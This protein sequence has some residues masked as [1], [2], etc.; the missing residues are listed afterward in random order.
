MKPEEIRSS[1]E[2]IQ[3]NLCKRMSTLESLTKGLMQIT[4]EIAAQLAEQRDLNRRLEVV[5]ARLGLS[6]DSAPG[7][8]ISSGDQKQSV[9]A[10]LG[11]SGIEPGIR[12][13]E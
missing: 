2:E 10:Q 8:G 9:Q 1:A 6:S 11:G 5:E 4:A 7:A 13:E 3:N 12:F